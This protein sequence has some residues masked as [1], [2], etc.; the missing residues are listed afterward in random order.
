MTFVVGACYGCDEPA[1]PTTA[2]PPARS[3]VVAAQV[4]E[5]PKSK[6]QDVCDVAPSGEQ[7]LALPA[8]VKGTAAPAVQ[9]RVW[10]NVWATWCKPCVEELP[11]LAAWRERLKKDGIEVSLLFVSADESEEAVATFNKE[12]QADVGSLRVDD[13]KAL[14]TWLT[15]VGLDEG[16]PLPIHVLTDATGGIRCVRAGAVSEGDYEAFSALARLE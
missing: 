6:P 7:K 4:K 9:G 3:R 13:P 14:P 15:S 5:E 8:L 11:M 2:A 1:T 16:A 10:L 12:T